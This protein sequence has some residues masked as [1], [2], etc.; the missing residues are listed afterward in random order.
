MQWGERAVPL[1]PPRSARNWTSSPMCEQI[2]PCCTPSTPSV[3]H[4]R[5]PQGH[6]LP[7]G[8][9]ANMSTALLNLNAVAQRVRTADGLQ[10]APWPARS[11]P[12]PAHTQARTRIGALAAAHACVRSWLAGRRS[13]GRT[14][15]RRHGSVHAPWRHG[16]LGCGSGGPSTCSMHV[17][18]ISG[19]RAGAGRQLLLW[20]K[21]HVKNVSVCVFSCG[22]CTRMCKYT[23]H[24]IVCFMRRS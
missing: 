21:A 11:M 12:W 22:L 9:H 18:C 23:I 14:S 19:Q 7:Q 1:R 8:E 2:S 10:W 13:Q 6:P 17:Q 4:A 5:R 20:G 24:K 16:A 3:R 15:M